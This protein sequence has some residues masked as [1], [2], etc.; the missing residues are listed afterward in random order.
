MFGHVLILYLN[1]VSAWKQD[2]SCL[3]GIPVWQYFFF[4]ASFNPPMAFCTLPL[5]LSL[6]RWRRPPPNSPFLTATYPRLRGKCLIAK[7]FAT[8]AKSA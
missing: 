3:D 8:L 4:R 6:K 1:S 5:V 2:A 7:S